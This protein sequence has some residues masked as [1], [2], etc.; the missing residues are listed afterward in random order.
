MQKRKMYYFIISTLIIVALFK[1][2]GVFLYGMVV[3]RSIQQD[4]SEEPRYIDGEPAIFKEKPDKLE[5]TNDIPKWHNLLSPERFEKEIFG[6]N[7][8]TTSNVLK[9]VSI[10]VLL[11]LFF[12]YYK[13]VRNWWD[14]RKRKTTPSSAEEKPRPLSTRANLNTVAK[15]TPTVVPVSDTELG[16]LLVSLNDALSDSQKR[17][18]HETVS[19]W[20]E[21]IQFDQSTRPYADVRY[22]EMDVIDERSVH[23]FKVSIRQYIQHHKGEKS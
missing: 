8:N 22:G 16:K 21:R 5:D 7:Q 9:W 6:K 12:K 10:G 11:I 1:I 23:D 17:T 14:K 15:T 20:F 3:D 18:S 13:R 2:S 19:E 4:L